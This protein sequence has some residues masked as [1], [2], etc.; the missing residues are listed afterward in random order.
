MASTARVLGQMGIVAL[1]AAVLSFSIP[2]FVDSHQFA[3]VARNYTK[4]PDAE[5]AAILRDESSKKNRIAL[6]TH[7]EIFA[8][9]FISLNAV[10]FWR[11]HRTSSTP[12]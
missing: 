3:E 6:T 5:N 7:L 11:R 2:V 12:G 10:W 1:L 9:L 4:N 8:V